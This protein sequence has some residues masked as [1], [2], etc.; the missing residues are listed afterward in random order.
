MT[1]RSLALAALALTACG[2]APDGAAPLPDAAPVPDAALVAPED[3]LPPLDDVALDGSRGDVAPADVP[4]A[5]D[6]PAGPDVPP[7]ETTD[8]Q[9]R[10]V[11]I[12]GSAC[13]NGTPTGFGVNRRPG[14]RGVLIFLQGGGACWDGASCWGPVSTSFFVATGYGR[15]QFATDVIALGSLFLRREAAAN[16]FRD[17][18]LVYVP[19]CTGDVHAGD[20]VAT[21]QWLGNRPTHHRGGH[22]L[23]LFLPRIAA[24]FPDAERVFLAGDSAGGFGVALNLHR[25]VE[26]FP[27]ARVAGLDDSGPPVQPAG[28]RWATWAAAWGVRFPPE[29]PAACATDIDVAVDV[30]R[31]RLGD[32][33]VAVVSFENDLVIRTFMGHD[34]QG[35]GLRLR[36]LARR[37]DAQWPSAR[38]FL[39]PGVSHVL[40]IQPVRPPGYD[41][42]VRRFVEG[43]P[44][45]RSVQP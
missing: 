6:A 41:D 22:N 11:D 31:R 9:W 7:V 34:A 21:H 20:R 32:T 39:T 42:W 12:P 26:A 38:Y 14:A 10:W 4:A 1:T 19:Y 8:N 18:N 27:R 44:T 29:C 36:A 45:L 23:G 28:D 24:T 30:Y 37:V 35:Y 17:F 3:A 5:P 25:V 43:D 33:R 2:G 15:L 16:P 40:E 13:A